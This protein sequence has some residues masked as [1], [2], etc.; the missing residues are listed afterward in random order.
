MAWQL[1]SFDELQAA[2]RELN[3]MSVPVESTIER[4]VTRSMYFP[5]PDGTRVEL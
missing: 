1:G 5:D 4:N 2:Y 3:A